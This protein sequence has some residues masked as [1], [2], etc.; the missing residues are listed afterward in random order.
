VSSRMLDVVGWDIGG[1]NIKAAR[2]LWRAGEIVDRRVVVRPFEIWRKPENLPGVLDEIGNELGIASTKAMALTMTA[3][4]SDTFRSKREGVLSILDTVEQV[5][6]NIP[7]YPLS[8]EGNFMPFSEAR[9]R[10]LDFAAS[11]WLASGLYVAHRHCDCILM[12]VGST[13]TDI[14]PIREGRVICTGRTDMERL[15]SGELVYSGILRTNP[16]TIVEQVPINGRMC[17]VAAELFALMADVYLL[18][19]CI[20]PETYTCP[21]ADG[22]AKSRLAAQERLARLVC[23][24]G[25]M[26]HEEQL[27]KLA[28]YLFEKQQQQLI[29][30]L[31]QVLSRLDQGYQM[32]LAAAGA[33]AF[34]AA[35]A[36][37]RLGITVLDLVK[38]WGATATAALP[39]QA[40]AYLLARKFS[41]E[42]P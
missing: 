19:G 20:S 33:G 15:T 36:G 37:Q 39:A 41:Q 11:N 40:A 9:Q 13:T 27:F 14:I 31:C 26:L 5:F 8:L 7:I 29:E 21:T 6:P 17:R 10:P 24:D 16:N 42:N 35:A 28:R 32:P 4:L 25:E 1:V 22:R 12:D 38:E 30:A 3:E 23:A 34:L 18:L 2:L